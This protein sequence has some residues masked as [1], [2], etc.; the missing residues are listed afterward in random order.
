M[1]LVHVLS[2]ST[3]LLF[4]ATT[5]AQTR[6]TMA[7]AGKS[8]AI[9]E[10]REGLKLFKEGKI[11][12]S[13]PHIKL[14]LEQGATAEGYYLQA[15]CYKK[16]AKDP[17]AMESFT[18]ALTL[19]A[20]HVE[21]L[22]QLGILEFNAAKYGLAAEHL[23]KAYALK[24]SD[25]QLKEFADKAK[26]AS[27]KGSSKSAPAT[28]AAP[29]MLDKVAKAAGASITSATAT[30]AATSSATAATTT[31]SSHVKLYNEGLQFL[32]ES[33][34]YSAITVFNK[35]LKESPNHA[36][37]YYN[38]GLAYREL[39]GEE[40]NAIRTITKAVNLDR[41]NA[42]Y[43][44]ALGV[45]YYDMGEGDKAQENFEGAYSLGMRTK[46]LYKSLASTYFF[47][48]KYDKAILLYETAVAEDPKD[49]QMLYNLGTA[50]LN[51]NKLNAAITT[52]EKV[53]RMDA[54]YKDAY[55]NMA[56]ALIKV[57]KY[58]ES[59]KI[60]EQLIKIDPDFAKGYLALA[61]AYS[62]MGDSYHQD[63][64]AKMAK[65]LD[66]TIKI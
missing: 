38:L 51:G 26:L 43:Q 2:F 50:Y 17:L 29:S 65:K 18:T 35:A 6:A 31:S 5:H 63:K 52:F 59:I 33:D 10:Y 1:K 40:S 37:T 32:K 66:P 11:T 7:V 42:K 64:Y 56:C 54:K 60:G 13:L 45:V 16:L 3:L 27:A 47:N 41:K 49:V 36:A 4:S 58:E 9:A 46:G 25:T 30:T 48:S 12:E 19:N 14:S 53:V 44:Y 55:Y 62:K 22:S 39:K 20:D 57:E 28:A 61:S 23:A 21:A 15:M 34:Y 24:P 8:L